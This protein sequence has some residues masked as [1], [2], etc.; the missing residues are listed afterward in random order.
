[1][2]I[3]KTSGICPKGRS[4]QKNKGRFYIQ[5]ND[6]QVEVRW[7]PYG[8]LLTIEEFIK[9][10]GN[11]DNALILWARAKGKKRLD[12]DRRGVRREPEHG[13]LLTYH[14]FLEKYGV[15]H[16]PILWT[17]S[18]EH[19]VLDIQFEQA[20]R[21]W[22]QLK[23][24]SF[25]WFKKQLLERD[26]P[27]NQENLF[28][29][30]VHARTPF[31]I[32]KGELMY[33]YG[34]DSLHH[35][36][37]HFPKECIAEKG[38]DVEVRYD[39]DGKIYCKTDYALYYPARVGLILWLWGKYSPGT[40][41]YYEPFNK[42]HLTYQKAQIMT[43]TDAFQNYGP[44]VFCQILQSKQ[45]RTNPVVKIIYWEI[46]EDRNT[47]E[48]KKE[49]RT[50]AYDH[51]L[52]G[53]KSI[54]ELWEEQHLQCNSRKVVV[55]ECYYD[56]VH[57]KL[58][59]HHSNSVWFING[60]YFKDYNA[61]KYIIQQT[62]DVK[63]KT[64]WTSA[65]IINASKYWYG[66]D[67]EWKTICLSKLLH[68][69]DVST[70]FALNNRELA[71]ARDDILSL[72]RNRYTQQ[73][74]NY[75]RQHPQLVDEEKNDIFEMYNPNVG[76]HNK[77]NNIDELKK[78]KLK[79]DQLSKIDPGVGWRRIIPKKCWKV[80]R[81]K[82]FKVTDPAAQAHI[83]QHL[84]VEIPSHIRTDVEVKKWFNMDR[85]Y[86]Y[87]KQKAKYGKSFR[88]GSGADCGGEFIWEITEEIDSLYLNN[89]KYNRTILETEDVY[90]NK[91]S[92][93]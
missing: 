40:P 53:T 91:W 30:C 16:A 10:F 28:K 35:N 79:L 46:D 25:Q 54:P 60:M 15:N 29:V 89:G 34:K 86:E 33:V 24:N 56:E 68:L 13:N 27:A 63:P 42:K 69:A 73:L 45:S 50:G 49:E 14:E 78:E 3:L 11:Q 55:F 62:S 71:I 17:C 92:T 12:L 59:Y 4:Y 81:K 65:Y 6:F 21:K 26:L 41:V 87:C 22:R 52:I 36:I 67:T 19:K 23:I 66:A 39:A 32:E 90:G 43:L 38:N 82:I 44:E 85:F 80:G 8:D 18:T 74:L 7:T 47:I 58:Q 20:L 5:N 9:V 77:V 88:L 57:P 31:H 37:E 51:H 93:R 48:T 72:Q 2:D 75:V 70:E 1:M 61:V 64:W 83:G 84:V 76:G